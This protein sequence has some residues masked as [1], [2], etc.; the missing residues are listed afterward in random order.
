MGKN[1]RRTAWGGHIGGFD[2]YYGEE[3]HNNST[4]FNISNN[5]SESAEVI[6]ESEYICQKST[7]FQPNKLYE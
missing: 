4:S 2:N 7:K 3:T 1:G 5:M 6:S